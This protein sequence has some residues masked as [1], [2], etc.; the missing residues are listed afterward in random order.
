MFVGC[1][2][3]IFSIYDAVNFLRVTSNHI[4]DTSSR[5]ILYE[6]F[7][8]FTIVLIGYNNYSYIRGVSS[9]AQRNFV[10]LGFLFLILF[11]INF[12]AGYHGYYEPPY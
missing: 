3:I 5:F 1:L 2:G 9:I 4:L 6:L 7:V 11:V 8:A 12:L 10:I